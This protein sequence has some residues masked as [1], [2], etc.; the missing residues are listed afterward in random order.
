MISIRRISALALLAWSCSAAQDRPAMSVRTVVEL[1]G[2]TG[3]LEIGPHGELYSS[4]FGDTL[5]RGPVGTRVFRI[6]PDGSFTVFAEGFHGASGNTID[7]AGN[8]LQ[9]NIAGN[10]VTVLRPD[11]T[12][13]EVGSEG[14]ANPVGI[15]EGP[16]G[17]YYV[18]SCGSNT[19]ER[20]TLGGAS[21]RFSSDPLL[22]C[23]N[24]IVYAADGNFYVSN[25]RNGDVVRLLRDGRAER[26]A[27]LPGDNNG[28][29]VFGNGVLYVAARGANQIYRV[30]L[31]GE[32]LLLAGSGE[33]G[34]A[35]GPAATATLSLPND[36][37]LS[38]D[39]AELYFNEVVPLDDP[40]GEK[41]AP[42]L[43]RALA[44][45]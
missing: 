44:L 21:T 31:E 10:T 39:G 7:T 43:V 24:G 34:H 9:S 23:P 5:N 40:T 41:L 16:G 14:L 37:A 15:V 13:A 30:T 28:H 8:F 22:A 19:I 2:G 36:L 45:R 6:S 1:P 12:R 25:F 26:L 38:A 35:D 27:T 4:E 20:I 18:A 11:G 29:L 17:D 32:V 3:G 33:R 42:T